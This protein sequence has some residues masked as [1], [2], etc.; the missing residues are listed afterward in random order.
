MYWNV[1]DLVD[2][3]VVDLGLTE[4]Y[5]VLKFEWKWVY[6]IAWFK[7]NRNIWCIEIIAILFFLLVYLCLTETYDVL[8]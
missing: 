8:K 1:V 5:D 4:T 3:L 2:D 7:F 6:V